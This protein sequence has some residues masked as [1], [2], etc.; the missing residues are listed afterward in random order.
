MNGMTGDWLKLHRATLNSACWQDM[1][2]G[3][4]WVNLLMRA[5]WETRQLLNGQVLQPGQMV[6]GQ[7]LLA[8]ELGMT[9]KEL[10][11]AMTRLVKCGNIATTGAKKGTTITILNWQKYQERGQIPGSATTMP[12]NDFHDGPSDEGPDRGQIGARKGPD[13]GQIGAIEEEGKKERREEGKKKKG[14]GAPDVIPEALDTPAF[15]KAWGEW[16]SYRSEARLK[17]WAPRT[18]TAQLK[19]LAAIGPG[20]AIECIEA[21]ISKGWAGLFPENHQEGSKA[22]GR[23]QATK[24]HTGPGQRFRPTG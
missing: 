1:K 11:C 15:I 12:D 22:N 8:Q 3:W 7:D 21:S 24:A 6:I 23:Q 18:R 2:T 4:L 20:A 17:R 5:N 14:A 13:R 10:R 19:K 16:H 9:R